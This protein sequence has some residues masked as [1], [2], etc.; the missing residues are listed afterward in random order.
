MMWLSSASEHSQIYVNA[1]FTS[2]SPSL[3]SSSLLKKPNLIVGKSM[4]AAARA[5]P[6]AESSTATATTTASS[7]TVSAAS[8][9]F[10][11]SSSITDTTESTDD[12]DVVVLCPTEE[13]QERKQNKKKQVQFASRESLEQVVGEVPSRN[14]LTDEDYESMWYNKSDFRKMKKDDIIPIVKKIVKKIPLE[15]DEEPRGLEHKTPRGSRDREDNRYNSMDAVLDEQERQWG[16]NA[17]SD[18]EKIAR[19]YHKFTAQCQMNAYLVATKDAE[20]VQQNNVIEKDAD[21]NTIDM[22]RGDTDDNI[23][24]KDEEDSVKSSNV[25]DDESAAELEEQTP[26]E[27]F[28][29]VNLAVE[30]TATKKNNN[31]FV[32]KERDEQQ[33]DG[34]LSGS[35][36]DGVQ[37]ATASAATKAIG[38]DVETIFVV[39]SIS[40]AKGTLPEER[41]TDTVTKESPCD[42][43][44]NICI[45]PAANFCVSPQALVVVPAMAL[46]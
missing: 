15:D 24:R 32:D 1:P 31:D 43:S 21:N 9:S 12:S 44:R 11:S 25:S 45:Q 19:K 3:S 6:I 20:W 4:P 18:P 37:E 42:L 35:T 29:T 27:E 33:Q 23:T 30:Q 16:T 38:E 34:Q 7:S 14:D 17:P 22:A 10:S 5:T 36:I 26:M 41:E 13:Q 28:V 40:L 2:L 46:S 8:S 39:S